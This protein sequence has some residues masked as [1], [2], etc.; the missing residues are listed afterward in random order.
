MMAGDIA[1]DVF[2]MPAESFDIYAREEHPAG[3]G[4]AGKKPIR[5]FR[6][7][8]QVLRAFKYQG[9]LSAYPRTSPHR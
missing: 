2:Y 8:P 1:P 9:K 4:F 5:R 7:L 3:P 6:L